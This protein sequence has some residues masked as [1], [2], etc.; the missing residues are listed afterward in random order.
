MCKFFL[1]RN[2][3]FNSFLCPPPLLFSRTPIICMLGLFH[4]IS[5]VAEG[6]SIFFHHFSLCIYLKNFFFFLGPYLWPMEVPKPGTESEL[7][8]LA[9]NTA[10]ATTGS[11]PHLQPTTACSNARSLTHYVRPGI[12]TASSWTLY[13]V[14]NLLSHNRNSYFFNF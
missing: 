7:Q 12:E 4:N 10:T 8:L 6:V 13:Q 1:Q 11:K 3:F 5:Q 14:H 2:Y 9:Y